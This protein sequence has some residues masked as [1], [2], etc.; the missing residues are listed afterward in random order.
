METPLK[1]IRIKRELS[2]YEVA[3]GV[4]CS[5]STVSRVER[6]DQGVSPDMAARISKFFGEGITEQEILYPERYVDQQA[7]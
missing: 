6:G 3:D 2:I 1:R 7:A 5:A 4:K